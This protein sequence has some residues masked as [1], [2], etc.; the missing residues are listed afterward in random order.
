MGLIGGGEV[1]FRQFMGCGIGLEGKGRN[2]GRFAER[3]RAIFFSNV[4]FVSCG[5]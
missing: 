1:C 4:R 3:F 5:G 2:L